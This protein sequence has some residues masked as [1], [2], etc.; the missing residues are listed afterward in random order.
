MAAW[1]QGPESYIG[2]WELKVKVRFK[3]TNYCGFGGYLVI[4]TYMEIVM[5]IFR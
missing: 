5:T 3:G 1:S 4:Y 2:A